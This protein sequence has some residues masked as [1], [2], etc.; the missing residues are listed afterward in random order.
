MSL[1]SLL[2]TKRGPSGYGYAS[3]AEQVSEGL[4]LSGKTFIVTGANTGLG[5]ET[6]RVL[7]MRGASVIGT[8][9]ST[10]KGEQVTSSLGERFKFVEC[11][12]SEPESIFGAATKIQSS[13]VNVSAVIA[14]AGV[15]GLPI[16][17]EKYGME[18]Q[19]L[20]NHL[21]H[22]IFVNS[23]IDH[24]VPDGRVVVLSSSA[25]RRTYA[26]GLDFSDLNHKEDYQKWRSYGQS[27]LANL[28][29]AREL[30]HQFAGTS[31]TA[32]AIHPGVIRT[33]LVRHFI[34]PVIQIGAKVGEWL[35]F[36]SLAQGAATQCYAAVHP[37]MAEVGGE[38]LYD[39]N[40][41]TSSVLGQ[42]RTAGE[43]LWEFSEKFSDRFR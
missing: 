16:Y 28:L 20:T 9:R 31:K 32:N 36:K 18:A 17:E 21:G 40:I 10:E 43:Q 33:E 8:V 34:N 27:K 14:N 22:F 39:S 4:D 13:S 30:N 41:Q 24:L 26:G 35:L 5:F 23:L 6:C 37:D 29:F 2:S 1:R 7:V 11:D 15:M 25:H 19:F 12:L 3:T 38:Y 42:D